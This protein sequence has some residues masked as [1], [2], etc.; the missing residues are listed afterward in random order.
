MSIAEPVGGGQPRGV[1][2]HEAKMCDEKVTSTDPLKFQDGESLS[3]TIHK[4]QSAVCE[5]YRIS[6]SEILSPRR[7]SPLVKARHV[8]MRLARD[9]T[10]ASLPEIGRIFDRDHSTVHHA[11][12]HLSVE[13]KNDISHILA[14]LEMVGKFDPYNSLGF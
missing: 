10:T 8:A 1:V 11:L 2:A 9:L 7:C 4:I 5:Y 6:L 14:K 3:T 13:A 12:N